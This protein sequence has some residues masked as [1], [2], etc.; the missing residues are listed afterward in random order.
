MTILGTLK[1][2]F[3]ESDE[4]LVDRMAVGAD[5]SRRDL[6]FKALRL[7]DE[8]ERGPWK[9]DAPHNRQDYLELVIRL[10]DLFPDPLE[11]LHRMA[12]E[13]PAP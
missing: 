12:T 9:A 3:A 11:F 4:D 2:F 10:A 6:F 13:D 5:A 7:L 8:L 1:R